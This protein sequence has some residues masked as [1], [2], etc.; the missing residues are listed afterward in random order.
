MLN[1]KCCLG[2]QFPR[3]WNYWDIE[4]VFDGSYLQD[5]RQLLRW[6]SVLHAHCQPHLKGCQLLSEEWTMLWINKHTLLWYRK[7]RKHI[8]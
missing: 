3:C 7:K 8:H 2:R 5:N 4:T 6:V 1:K